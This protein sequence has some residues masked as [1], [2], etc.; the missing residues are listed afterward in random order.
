MENDDISK[1]ESNEE[2]IIYGLHIEG[3]NKKV[4][5]RRNFLK[6]AAIAGTAVALTS[7]ELPGGDSSSAT[8]IAELEQEV[9]DSEKTLAAMENDAE[10][11]VET[12]TP[13]SAIAMGE[14]RDIIPLY[15]GP[16]Q[17]M[18]QVGLLEGN[19]DVTIL[20]RNPDGTWFLVES[21]K[22]EIG[23]VPNDS[24]NVTSG[25]TSIPVE[26]NYPTPKTQ[27]PTTTPEPTATQPPPTATSEVYNCTGI[28]NMAH[29]IWEGPDSNH[30]YIGKT[31][32]DDEVYVI[33]KTDD[34]QWF[35]IYTSDDITGWCYAT[36][37]TLQNC[38]LWEI[39]VPYSI[40]TQPA[41]ACECDAYVGC[42]CDSYV[43]CS[44]DTHSYEYC[45]CDTVHYWYPN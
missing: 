12:A 42:D 6:T 7:C 27:T 26:E 18:D 8:K 24:I 9:A 38:E 15:A 37:I 29:S 23:W 10:T 21:S 25:M 39:K 5:T 11:K 19:Q 1:Q 43:A 17:S 34:N 20:A 31:I 28:V 35:K 40:P 16:Y 45:T 2:P 13:E 3:D 36:F 14:T 41:P 33:G 44:C 4:F 30:P 22:G 32:L